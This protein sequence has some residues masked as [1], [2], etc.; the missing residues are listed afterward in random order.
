MKKNCSIWVY[1]LF[2]SNKKKYQVT[3]FIKSFDGCFKKFGFKS[4]LYQSFGGSELRLFR[5]EASMLCSP[6]IRASFF[7][8]K[9]FPPTNELHNMDREN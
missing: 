5:R 1:F 7:E 9:N 4:H 6:L 3:M 2:V 8:E